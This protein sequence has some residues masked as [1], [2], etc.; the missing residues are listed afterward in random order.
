MIWPT[1]VNVKQT[2]RFPAVHQLGVDS[3]SDK[4]SPIDLLKIQNMINFIIFRYPIS[5]PLY[6]VGNFAK[7][8]LYLTLTPCFTELCIYKF[9]VNQTKKVSEKKPFVYSYRRDINTFYKSV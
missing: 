6:F 5:N 9:V 7:V 3:L 8:R 2:T 1:E 4:I